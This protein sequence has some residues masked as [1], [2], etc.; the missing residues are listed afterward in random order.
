MCII[1]IENSIYSMYRQSCTTYTPILILTF[2][3]THNFF[4]FK[5]GLFLDQWFSNFLSADPL[6]AHCTLRDPSSLYI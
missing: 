3:V 1:N 2:A 6:I 4:K 5:L